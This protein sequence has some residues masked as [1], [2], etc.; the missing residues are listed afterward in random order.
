MVW[1]WLRRKT[2]T[3]YESFYRDFRIAVPDRFNYAFD[4]LDSI[5][6]KDPSRR[7]LVWCDDHAEEHVFTMAI[8]L[9]PVTVRRM[10]SRRWGFGVA[11]S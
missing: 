5:A 8:S 9:V 3:S 6:S 1:P 4:V 11:M 2:F 7:A 10:C